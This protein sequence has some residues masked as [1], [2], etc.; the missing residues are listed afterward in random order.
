[1]SRSTKP[2]RLGDVIDTLVDRLGIRKDLGEAEIIEAWATLAGADV[3]ARTESAWLK[4]DILFVR[5]TSPTLRHHLHMQR[6]EWRDRL[7]QELGR[8]AIK[9]I[10][11]R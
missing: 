11:F 6:T 5:I 10:S 2:R 7:N 1:M 3:N 8:V 9:A 4:G